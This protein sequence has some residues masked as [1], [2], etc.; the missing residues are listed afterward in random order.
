MPH[1]VDE[2]GAVEGLAAQDLLEIGRDLVVVVPVFDVV[3]DIL[4]HVHHFGVGS[5]VARALEGADR[6]SVG[7][8]GIRGG[9]GQHAAGEGGV[10]AAAV[11]GVEHEH[12]VEQHGFAAGEVVVPAKH[13]QD[14]FRCGELGVGRGDERAAA[15]LAGDRERMGHGGDARQ[16]GEHGDGDVD[17]VLGRDVVR[18]GIEGVQQQH[19]AHE[20]VHDGAGD[21]GDGELRHVAIGDVAVCA[22]ARLKVR[23]LVYVGQGAGDEQVGDLFV[24]KAALRL[25]AIDKVLD[26]VTAKRQLA[27]VRNQLAVHDV[28]AVDVADAGEAGHHA[29]TVRVAQAALDVVLFV[30]AFVIGLA[31]GTVVEALAFG[32]DLAARFIVDDQA[33]Q[34]IVEAV[35]DVLRGVSH[36]VP[37]IRRGM[38]RCRGV[39]GAVRGD[40]AASRA[41]RATRVDT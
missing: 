32:G 6:R 38:R 30:E 15:L 16:A 35:V 37:P 20:H 40:G 41:R 8:V 23:E 11:L 34:R 2:A 27:L 9:T 5:A 1:A 36:G 29:G 14:S 25:R 10:V 13:L 21:R 3:T 17:L 19:G 31:R 26:A 18:L 24:T 39:A 12:D 22:Q 7:G 28:V 33:A 4:V